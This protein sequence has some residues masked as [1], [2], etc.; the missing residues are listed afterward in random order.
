MTKPH[1][2][3]VVADMK[4]FVKEPWRPLVLCS[5][6]DHEIKLAL[7]RGEYFWHKHETHDEFIFV[8]DGEVKIEFDDAVEELAAGEGVFI[9][10]GTRH[11]S[12]SLRGAL[13]LLFERENILQ[14]FIRG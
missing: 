2:K 9:A 1:R 7:F 5:V 8:L 13:V 12:S 4:E 6:E 11:R 10:R 14:D 3:I